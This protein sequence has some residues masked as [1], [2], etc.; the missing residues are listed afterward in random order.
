MERRKVIV[1]K[2]K[3]FKLRIILG[4]LVVGSVLLTAVVGGYL[5]ITAN[6]K[7][8]TS[9]YLESNYQYA[10][11]LATNTTDILNIMQHNINSIAGLAGKPSFSQR[12]LDI[13]FKA[14]EQYFNSIVIVDE[15]RYIKSVTP[16]K[17]Y[18]LIGS[19]LTSDASIEAVERKAATISEP[20]IATTGR[21]ILLVS[22]PIYDAKGQYKGFAGGTIYL[23]EDNVLSRLLSEHFYGNGSYVY[24]ADKHAHLIFHPDSER[25]NEKII[26]NR[27][28]HKALEG[29]SGSAEITNSQGNIFFSGYAY[30]P[31]AGW[32][33]VSQTPVSVLDKPL[34]KLAMHIVF[35]AL[36]VCIIILFVAWRVSRYISLPLYELARFSEEAVMSKKSVPPEMPKIAS[37]IYEVK[38]LHE[39][40]GNHLN[41]L[42]DEI[43]IDGLTGLA[44]RKTFDLTLQE[45]MEEQVP[46]ALVLIDIDYFKRVNDMYGHAVGDEMLQHLAA[47]MRL[48]ARPQDLSFRYGGEEFGILVRHEDIQKSYEIAEN[49]RLKMSAGP[50]PNGVAVTISLGITAYTSI[51]HLTAKELV[52]QADM[53]LYRSKQ[54]GRNRT[55]AFTSETDYMK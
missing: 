37:L 40:I 14:N 4:L 41:L 38:Q 2:R 54:G 6:V 42:N 1:G 43:Q 31:N 48:S 30:E 51:E 19:Q 21:L 3:G 24:V 44:N 12:D 13:W 10:K 45:W 49:L 20:Y 50:G 22:S 28:I 52:E 55:T 8:L 33:I 34:R 9:N 5:A 7:S 26:G 39:S 27:V 25:I 53:A 15:D 29:N 47:E 23:Q 32:G 17:V 35:Q 11:K 18:S 16:D 36:P 46:F